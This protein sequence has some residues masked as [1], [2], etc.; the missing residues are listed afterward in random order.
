MPSEQ[1]GAYG[2]H[3]ALLS[4]HMERSVWGLGRTL[5]SQTAR[6]SAHA[7]SVLAGVS[8]PLGRSQ[9]HA[10]GV[11]RI[12]FI[13][14]GVSM[15]RSPNGFNPKESLPEPGGISTAVCPSCGSSGLLLKNAQ[16]T[17]CRRAGCVTCQT[18]YAEFQS[19]KPVPGQAPRAIQNG[20]TVTYHPGSPGG[21]VPD[22]R[23]PYRF[24]SGDCFD[25]W[26]WGHIASGQAPLGRGQEWTLAGFVLRQ[27]V[28]SRAVT[29]YQ[30]HIRQLKLQH[31]KRL[32]DAE[33][34]EAA[35][36]IYQEL[37]MWKEA[38]DIRRQ[39]RR[40]VVTQVQ[41]DLNGLIDQL[42][43]AGLSTNF[44]CPACGGRIQISGSTFVARLHSC[45]FCGSAIQ[46]ADVT[47][48]LLAVIGQR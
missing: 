38:G 4:F 3:L 36:Q 11:Q 29:M 44:T 23:T 13:L 39:S 1:K 48:F 20:R 17:G 9:S 31:A 30:N 14:T 46:T 15:S 12:T 45:E 24:C 7:I 2:G 42:R 40:Q 35:A 22:K 37:G 21:Y 5:G 25:R 6:R 41:V 33:Q 47:A 18:A 19:Y 26:A 43:K 34:T 28:A 16:C 32:I 8:P 10:R 27:D